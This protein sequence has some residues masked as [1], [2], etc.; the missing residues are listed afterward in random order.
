MPNEVDREG[1]GR[2]LGRGEQLFSGLYWEGLK[3]WGCGGVAGGHRASCPRDLTLL[4]L[5]TPGG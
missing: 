3:Q 2:L 5:L 4:R 1:G